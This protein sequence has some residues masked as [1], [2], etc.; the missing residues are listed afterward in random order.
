MAS[1]PEAEVSAN[2]LVAAWRS[3][4]KPV[5]LPALLI[6]LAALAFASWYGAAYGEEAETAFTEL[7]NSIGETVG[8]WYVLLVTAFLVFALWAA[9][10]RAGNIRLGREDE[11]PEFSLFSWFAMLFS[12][13]MGIGLVF[14]GVAEPLNHMI[15]PPDI[16]DVE[17][18]TAEAGRAA[19]GQA[20][21][22]W[23]LHA[24]GI[25][26]LVGLGLAY[27]S[28][29]RGRPLSVRWLL[30]PIFGRRLIESWVGHVVDVF[31]IVGTIFGVATS[32]GQGVLQIQAGLVHLGWFEPSNFL[33]LALVV[34]IT[35]VGTI[36]VITGLHKGLRWLSNA[37]MV[38]AAV[39]A[40]CVLLIGPTVFLLQSVVQNTGEYVQAIPQLMFVT[41]AG[42]KDDWTLNWTL[43][44]QGWFLSWAP[45][46][47][48]FIARISRSR[49]IREF[50]L[51]VMLAPTVIAI[52]WF[53][54]F[55]STGIRYQ[56]ANGTMIGQDGVV[57]TDTSLFLLFENL[58]VSGGVA[59]AMSVIA[60]LVITLFFIT[61]SDS[62]SLVVDVLSHGG[63]TETPWLTR[64]FWAVIL[65]AAGALLLLSGGEAALTVLQVSSIAGAAPLSVIYAFTVVALVRMFRYEMAIMP[66]YVRVRS[67]AAPSALVA[68]ARQQSADDQEFQGNL[69]RLL[70]SWSDG[71]SPNGALRGTSAVLGGFER[72]AP[73]PSYVSTSDGT[74][75]TVLAVH[76]VPAHATTVDAE[77][78]A[79][80]RAG[81]ST[82]ED[83]IG[84]EV[85]DTPEF[86]ASAVGAEYEAEEL[87][88]RC[89]SDGVR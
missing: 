37:N 16:A 5:F 3:L 73:E 15:S 44:D 6:I 69:R 41:G 23:G 83:P 2:P 38:L 71:T 56:L 27:M 61:S 81:D 30:E 10:S 7:R 65:G 66:R 34:L 25:Y 70:K 60:I 77:T 58:P 68:T 1:R 33:L 8:W 55:G 20:L 88:R 67:K 17:A 89:S 32:L 47:G 31:A 45:F 18:G 52:L 78:G 50:V 19:I 22:H 62:C 26:V 42:A 24:W 75:T 28:F 48:M 4:S 80:E 85:F 57:D 35:A 36:S 9:L 39:L 84:G 46:V 12:A 86:E 43:F 13:G 11:R 64:L 59:V 14:W 29:R 63:R 72:T 51:G 49:T 74:D 87:L 82:V 54:V 76:D 53:T 79:I 21:F 40:V